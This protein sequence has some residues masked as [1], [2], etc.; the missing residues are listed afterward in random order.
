M[1]IFTDKLCTPLFYFSAAD[2]TYRTYIVLL[3]FGGDDSL[4]PAFVFQFF[5]NGIAQSQGRCRTCCAVNDPGIFFVVFRKNQYLCILLLAII[6]D[7]S[8]KLMCI[9]LMKI[10][11]F[12]PIAMI[13]SWIIALTS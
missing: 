8:A 9:V 13:G 6:N 7:L 1:T 3:H 10:F 12:H 4:L 11:Q 2:C 5:P